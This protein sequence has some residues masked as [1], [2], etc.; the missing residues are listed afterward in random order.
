MPAYPIPSVALPSSH[1]G[2]LPLFILVGVLMG[3]VGPLYT[4]VKVWCTHFTCDS[5]S[6]RL[7]TLLLCNSTRPLTHPHTPPQL[8]AWLWRRLAFWNAH[9][10]KKYGISAL[11]AAGS[12]VLFFTPGP[13]FRLPL[14]LTAARL[15]SPEVRVLCVCVCV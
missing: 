11:V 15:I 8:Q 9:R 13:F 2:H 7:V 6:T 3:L 12:A 4:R 14:T 10:S 5:F 1:P